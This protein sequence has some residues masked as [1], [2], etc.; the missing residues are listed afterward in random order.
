MMRLFL[1]ILTLGQI[2][3]AASLEKITINETAVPLIYEQDKRLPI[4]SMQIIFINSGH[5][6]D[7][8]RSGLAKLSAKMMNEGTKTLGSNAFAAALEAKAIHISTNIGT[9]TF[10]ME[11]SC[12][13]DQFEEGVEK[14]ISLIQDPNITEKTLEKIKTISIGG[15]KRRESDFDYVASS[16]LKKLQYP[17]SSLE[18]PSDGTIE[19]IESISLDEIKAFLKKHLVSERVI[20]VVGGDISDSEAKKSVTKV[21]SKLQKGERGEAI[22]VTTNPKI[23]ESILKRTTE[24]AY[25]YFGSPFHMQVNDVDYYKARVAT[26]ILGAGGFGS[27]LMEEIRVKRGLAYSAYARVSV[28]A[29]HSAFSG[30]LQTKIESLKEAQST[31]KEVIADFV[32]DGVTQAELDH[33]KKF[34]LGSEPL[35]VET[36]SQRLS[37]T[38]LEYY[39]GQELGHAAK[40]L[41][42]ISNLSLDDLNTFVKKHSEINDLSFAI[43]TE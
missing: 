30:Y 11:L 43:V 36:L 29:S 12:L 8:N 10:V 21:V 9:E 3:M 34:L 26:Y 23:Q 38:F 25:I 19:L 14:L 41:E 6:E 13:K 40:E 42:L 20:A 18:Y 24:Q 28:S 33:A 35:R 4:V 5:I 37:R 32:K 27:R 1:L 2:L 15:L 7:A 39:K 16:E 17:N 31:V 22:S